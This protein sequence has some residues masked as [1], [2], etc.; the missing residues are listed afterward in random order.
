[1]YGC[2][3]WFV[4]DLVGN[5]EDQFSHN[6]AHM[7]CYEKTCLL[8]MQK[9]RHRSAGCSGAADQHLC[10]RFIDSTIPLLPKSEIL[11][12]QSFTVPVEPGLSRVATVREKSQE[13]EFFSRSGKSQGISILV[14]E[15]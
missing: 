8:H 2:R 13:N 11:S 7:S 14:R 10:F 9:Q 4:L 5:S 6:E 1:M 15:I 3:A 12:L